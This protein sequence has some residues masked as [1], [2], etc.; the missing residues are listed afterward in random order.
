MAENPESSQGTHSSRH[1]PQGSLVTSASGFADSTISFSTFATGITDGSLCLSQFPPPPTTFST[2]SLGSPAQSNFT[3]TASTPL[4]L[5]FPSPAESSFTV[6]AP[7][8]ASPVSRIPS[9]IVQP[10]L[11]AEQGMVSPARSTFTVAPQ[12]P[13]SPTRTIPVVPVAQPM[14]PAVNRRP[15]PDGLSSDKPGK[16]VYPQHSVP[17]GKEES[18]QNLTALFLAGRLSPFDWHEGS[19]IISVDPAEERMLSTSF[20][21]G[22]LSSANPAKASGLTSAPQTPQTSYQAEVGTPVSEMSYP[23]SSPPYHERVAGPTHFPPPNMYPYWSAEEEPEPS[24]TCEDETVTSYEAHA[25]VVQSWPAKVSVVGMS[26]ATLHHFSDTNDMPGSMHPQSPGD[27]M[28]SKPYPPSVFSSVIDRMRS[29]DIQPLIPTSRPLTGATPLDSEL[30]TSNRI[31]IKFQRRGSV[32][33]TRTVRSH[34]SSLISSAGQRTARAARATKEWLRIKPLPPIPTIPNVSLS[35][36]REH[37]RMEDA[38]PL[39]QLAERADRLKTMLNSG[40]LSRDSIGSSSGLNSEKTFPLGTRASGV[41]VALGGRRRQSVAFGVP[42]PGVPDRPLKS[43]SLFKRPISRNAMI[44]LR[45]AIVILV[46]LVIVGVV[47]GVVVGREHSRS[48]KCPA[49]RT[50]NT[51]SLS[52]PYA[53]CHLR[54]ELILGPRR[55]NVCLYLVQHESMQPPCS[56]SCRPHP[57]CQWPIQCQ[58]YSGHCRGCHIQLSRVRE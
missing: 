24:I 10:G 16:T 31:S 52:K 4:R 41:Q 36:E 2:P 56:E 1:R 12:A 7:V 43:K 22:L 15:S 45:I 46:L 21:T 50:G 30:G 40:H 5:A 28:T 37:R 39:P 49:N 25:N 13:V 14:P 3:V 51:C 20:I 44:K 58:L 38:V 42:E 35:Q 17:R 27:T 23:P 29:L 48:S 33:S 9:S 11:I 32:Y 55:L 19:S 8:P 47:V 6:T 18:Q 54:S 53:S 57:Y 26:P 34:V